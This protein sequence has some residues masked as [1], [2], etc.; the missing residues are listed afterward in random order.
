MDKNPKLRPDFSDIRAA[1]K[2]RKVTETAVVQPALTFCRCAGHHLQEMLDCLA[3][4]WVQL[5]RPH[6]DASAAV[7]TERVEGPSAGSSD[8]ASARPPIPVPVRPIDTARSPLTR[9]ALV[10]VRGLRSQQ[11]QAVVKDDRED[12]DEEISG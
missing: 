8:G 5:E 11:Q 7:L 9:E 10:S 6:T 12:K 2:A 1:F 4:G 3:E